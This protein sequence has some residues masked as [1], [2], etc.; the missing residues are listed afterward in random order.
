[1]SLMQHMA[2]DA[3]TIGNSG[4]SAAVVGI[5]FYGVSL[6][7]IVAGISG[8]YFIISTVFLLMKIYRWLK[9]NK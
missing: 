7:D 6:P 8:V 3:G 2:Q 4:M 5:Q 1:M 9:E